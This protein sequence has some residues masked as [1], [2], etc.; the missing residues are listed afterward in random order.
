MGDGSNKLILMIKKLMGE[1]EGET[2]RS[3]DGVDG[4]VDPAGAV[5]MRKTDKNE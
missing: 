5:L 4:L 3:E 1:K 2:K